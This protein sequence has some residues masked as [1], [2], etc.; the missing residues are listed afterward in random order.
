MNKNKIRI[1]I[2]NTYLT[3]VKEFPYVWTI[4]GNK[5]SKNHLYEMKIYLTIIIV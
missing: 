3:E 5:I 4:A 1:F 2:D